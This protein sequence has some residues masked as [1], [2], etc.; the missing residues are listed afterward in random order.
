[1]DDFDQSICVPVEKHQLQI[2]LPIASIGSLDYWSTCRWL[3]PLL[4]SSEKQC[5]YF[6]WTL[7]CTSISEFNLIH[8]WKKCPVCNTWLYIALLFASKLSTFCEIVDLFKFGAGVSKFVK[9]RSPW[10]TNPCSVGRPSRYGGKWGCRADSEWAKS[11]PR[12]SNKFSDFMKKVKVFNQ[13]LYFNG[14]K[15]SLSIISFRLLTQW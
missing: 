7:D 6:E 14:R 9:N 5:F 15:E 11:A 4:E 2:P 12:T 8:N 10:R 3:A 13:Q 1:M